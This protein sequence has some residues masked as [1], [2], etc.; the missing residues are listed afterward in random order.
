MNILE[1]KAYP[2]IT[3]FK[4]EP[5]QSFALTEK[6]EIRYFYFSRHEELTEFFKFF[7][8]NLFDL[9]S[10]SLK[11]LYWFLLL[12]IY[13]KQEISED[14]K[15]KIYSFIQKCEVYQG[16]IVGFKRTPYS[17]QK[18]GD[19]H[20]TYFATVSL[21]LM[22]Y[23]DRYIASKGKGLVM[24]ALKNFIDI[25]DKGDR[26]VH[27][28]EGCEIC[29]KS[30]PARTLY[31]VL[32]ILTLL[33]FE[34][35][36]YKSKYFPY[37][38]KLKKR[39]SL[40][41]Q[42][43][44]YKYFDL[45]H[46][47]EEEY[48]EFLHQFQNEDGGFSVEGIKGN[49]NLTFWITNILESY[50]WLLNYN[51]SG[52]YN[53]VNSNLS[54]ILMNKGSWDF[55]TLIQFSK[56]IIIFSLIWSK[57]IEEI[58]RVIFKQIENKGYI[59]VKQLNSL[60]GL[61]EVLNEV[62]S[63]INLSY[64]FNLKILTNKVE[65]KNYLRNLS[66]REKILA[67]ELYERL[68]NKS[69]V[70]LT[71]IINRYNDAYPS[72][73]I[74]IK[75]FKP[76]IQDMI[77]NHYFEGEITTK[78]KYLILT[79]H[80]FCLDFLLEKIIV[81]DTKINS[82]RIFEEKRLQKD[83][84]N[85]I[86]NMTLKLKNTTAQIE[87]EIESYLLID[88]LE[89]A[90]DR[91]KYI[92]RNALFESDFLNE[93]IENSFNEDLYYINIHATLHSEIEKWNKMYSILSK[94]LKEIDSKLKEKIAEKEELRKYNRILDELDNRL[95]DLDNHFNKR[96]DD[97]RNFL[98]T[99]L[100][101]GYNQQKLKSIKERFKNIKTEVEDFDEK[102]YKISQQI[103]LKDEKLSQKHKSIISYWKSIK[104]ELNQIFEYY[105][106]GLNFF[107]GIDKS[108]E[109][110]HDDLDNELS[111]I[112]KRSHNKVQKGRFQEAFNVI[113]QQSKVL[114]DNKLEK[115][116]ELQKGVKNEIKSRQKLYSL[117][118]HLQSKLE[119]NEEN[120]IEKVAKEIQTIENKV[121]EERNQIIIDKF[122]NFV[123]TNI[124]N[125]REKLMDYQEK[126][127]RKDNLY[128]LDISDVIEGFNSISEY[129]E[130]IKSSYTDKLEENRDLIENFE[131][132]A[133]LT[134]MQWE[135][136]EEYINNEISNLKEE[137]INDII[138]EKIQ[139]LAKHSDSNCLS[140]KDVFKNIS[141]DDKE[142]MRRIEELIKVSKLN[143]EIIEKRKCLLIY[144][145]DYYKNQELRNYINNKILKFK[146]R[147]I[148]KTLALYDSCIKNSTL[149]INSAEIINRIEDLDNFDEIMEERFDKKVKELHLDIDS[150][151]EFRE[152]ED[153]FMSI[154]KNSKLAIK[155]IRKSVLTFN[156]LLNFI[157]DSYNGLENN[158]NSFIKKM[159]SFIEDADSYTKIMEELDTGKEKFEDLHKLI[160]ENILEKLDKTLESDE[161]FEKLSPELHELFVREKRE[162]EKQ[163]KEKMEDLNQKVTIKRN[164]LFRDDLISHIKNNK[165]T[166]NHLLGR[167]QTR[168]E[169]YIEINEFERAY[170]K[171]TEKRETIETEIEIMKTEIKEVVKTYNKQT[172][173]FE[174]R[175]KHILNDFEK[176]IIEYNAILSEKAKSL[177]TLVL[178]HYI[179][180][181]IKG[182]TNEYLSVSFI[183][184]DL[185][186]KRKEI[187][188]FILP[189]SSEKLPGKFD[190]MLDIYYENPEIL[191]ELDKD[192]LE[193]IK[194]MNYKVYILLNRLKNITKH[195]YPIIA[196]SASFLTLSFYLLQLTKW[197]P[198]V[199]F[200]PGLIA[201]AIL[202]F[203]LKRKKESD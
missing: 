145:Q 91:L 21:H 134:I 173:D 159:E 32:E 65:F 82:E 69:I 116:K 180:M 162:M 44:C 109:K 29:D 202:Y 7:E 196:F 1:K 187:R 176:Y 135:R 57:F 86:F 118:R 34:V 37:I 151:K 28:L 61:E 95:H 74:T 43:L 56:L 81:S 94:K 161:K 42:L 183:A 112:S 24:A 40:I 17:E 150:K 68:S 59:D 75:Q 2:Y 194:S 146:N 89:I 191:D 38:G 79:K 139:Y 20:S 126:L 39:F 179:R 197:N 189:L 83:I 36:A 124:G 154:I 12:N 117:Y 107:K 105:S 119:K 123:S 46:R 33:G 168:I 185:G 193:V 11:N 3:E 25:H 129:F 90:K 88:E 122:D 30:H 140:F 203:L 141:I 182:V 163:M 98:R 152:T 170:E 64:T 137:Y 55:K 54:K 63:Y 160:Q 198:L 35:R 13:L 97:F 62:I 165:I 171:I 80:Y 114:L 16:D 103:T 111:V 100:E 131:K 195:Y 5:Y 136:F 186:A 93:N 99:Q 142:A 15:E 22:G 155:N 27:C 9:Q 58:E 143:G 175:H 96:I 19:I 147:T 149:K 178:E 23:L 167:L 156:S 92:I 201:V 200:I 130:E 157:H 48:L 188:N 45:D 132:K 181:A 102:V 49:T 153:A 14:I 158:F 101:G 77:D 166:L 72:D 4:K 133:N 70:S 192:E 52:I 60:F 164:E 73:E 50:I 67:E 108:V 51:P 177:K 53:F 113:K 148:G 174:R 172:K 125:C 10:L 85:D 110:V 76:I 127:D 47:V 18:K 169:D 41:F 106:E 128:K 121:I 78:K 120:I 184:K 26:F 71:D 84:K 31:Y 104:G 8:R 6:T 138:N 115:I 199:L 144:N 66:P 87:E 190:P